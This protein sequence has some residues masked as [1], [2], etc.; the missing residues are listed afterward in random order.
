MN[1]YKSFADLAT[2]LGPVMQSSRETEAE[3]GPAIEPRP[4]P[5]PEGPRIFKRYVLPDE[6]P[7]DYD[8][9]FWR[10]WQKEFTACCVALASFFD[11]DE[12]SQFDPIQFIDKCILQGME[13]WRD[14]TE[15]AG[16]TTKAA[17]AVWDRKDS[18]TEI[19]IEEYRQLHE[20]LRLLRLKWS[21]TSKALEAG[22]T[23]RHR[24]VSQ[25]GLKTIQPYLSLERLASVH[26]TRREREKR[27][28]AAMKD[29]EKY[30][31][32]S[33]TEYRNRLAHN[34][35][36]SLYADGVEADTHT[37]PGLKAV[38]ADKAWIAQRKKQG[39]PLQR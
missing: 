29:A 32:M 5:S 28:F 9:Q 11:F 22:L 4:A 13:R 3:Y 33:E 19:D 6:D 26:R 37:G 8:D 23:A 21:R 2:A 30:L 16:E 39:L 24:V 35:V 12:R 25:S 14:T 27:D 18:G 34:A 31:N 38:D 1:V 15:D 20:R 7:A 36:P 10:K 17:I